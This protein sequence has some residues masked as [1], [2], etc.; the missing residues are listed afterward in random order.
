MNVQQQI[1]R[2]LNK[3]FTTEHFEMIDGVFQL[4]CCA[5]MVQESAADLYFEYSQPDEQIDAIV[6]ALQSIQGDEYSSISKV[7]FGSP[8]HGMKLL[9]EQ[10]IAYVVPMIEDE[11]NDYMAELLA[12]NHQ[13]AADDHAYQLREVVA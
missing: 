8:L 5:P 7:A 4:S 10:I 2:E 3:L 13:R 6:E 1:A 9:R 12:V 11:V